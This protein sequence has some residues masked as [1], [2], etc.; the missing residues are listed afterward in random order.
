[1]NEALR[2]IS[3]KKIAVLNGILHGHFTGSVEVVRELAA[4]G[5]DITCFVTDEFADRLNDIPVKKVVYSADVSQVAK[6][7]PPTAPPFAI[8]S[9]MV[10]RATYEVM[11]LLMKD[12]TEYDYYIVDAFFDIEEMNKVLKLDPSKF[13]MIYPSFIL[14]DENQF[15]NARLIGLQ[16]TNQHYGINLRDFVGLIFTPNNFKKLLLTS[17]YFHLRPEDTDDTC[18][19]LGPHIEQRV[20]DESFDFKK[21]P[22]KRLLFISLGTIFGRDLEFY[23]RCI[24]AFGGSEQYQ[25]IMSVGKF[26]NIEETFKEIPENFTVYNYV[27]QTQLLPQVDVFITHAGFNSTSEGLASGASLVLVPQAVDQFDVAKVVEGLNAGIALNKHEIDITADIIKN[28]VDTAYD[29]REEFRAAADVILKSFREARSNRT[30][31]YGEIF[32]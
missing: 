6:M 2:E 1:M 18:Y 5:H 21:D 32:A 28:A 9:F 16:W 14:T 12:R 27:P 30:A 11:E 17:K 7:L 24:E 10:G 19:F 22:D 4:L 26:V 3:P 25:V 8:N 29:R 20:V 23:H 13:V 31:L 15:D